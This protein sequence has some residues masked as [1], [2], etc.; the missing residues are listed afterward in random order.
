MTD[1][2]I[3][4]KTAQQI[5]IG[6]KNSAGSLFPYQGCFFSKMR[7]IAANQGMF[8]GSAKS[9][10]VVD[11]V[12]AALSRTNLAFAEQLMSHFDLPGQSSG[13]IGVNIG[14]CKGGHAFLFPII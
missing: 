8:A 13:L 4:T 12:H 14:W 3:L 2:K 1:F 9:N 5:A 11:P 10:L 6:K 7:V